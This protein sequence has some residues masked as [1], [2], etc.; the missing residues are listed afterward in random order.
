LPS[1]IR[2]NVRF[3]NEISPL[4]NIEIYDSHVAIQKGN[5]CSYFSIDG[6]MM[7]A[8]SADRTY[9][10]NVIEHIKKQGEE[11]NLLGEK[12]IKYMKSLS[13]PTRFIRGLQYVSQNEK[14]GYYPGGPT[15]SSHL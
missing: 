15:I 13:L 2:Y 7:L 1:K 10:V 14:T 9:A 3:K 12:N 6:A 11:I 4:A 8:T 5:G